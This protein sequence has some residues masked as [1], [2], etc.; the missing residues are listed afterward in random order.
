MPVE[1]SI[2][3]AQGALLGTRALSVSEVHARIHGRYPEAQP[4]PGR[5]QLDAMMLKLELGFA[6]DGK[7]QYGDR[8]GAYC[9]PQ[10]GLTSYASATHASLHYTKHNTDDAEALREVRAFDQTVQA[11]IASARFLALSVRPSQW[12][13]AIDKLSKTF[14]FHIISFDE[15]LLR[16]LHHSCDAMTRP[17]NWQVVLRA[18]V[19]DRS[20]VDWSRLQ[21]LVRRVLPAMSDEVLATERPVLLTDPG[22]IAR[23]ELINSWLSELRQHLINGQQAHALVLLIANGITTTGAIIDGTAVPSGAGSKEF[24][25]IPS[26][27]L[28]LNQPVMEPQRN[29]QGAVP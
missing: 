3:L 23:Y 22:L 15:L 27:W 4:L 1:R 10:A 11:T 7:A 9:L 17:P 26:A 28:Q 12:Q 19:A 2:E 18:G 13:A 16:H 21:G 6:W 8:R 25:R 29:A 24:A 20:S 5:P 14:D